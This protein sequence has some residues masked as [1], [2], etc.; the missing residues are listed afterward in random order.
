[1]AANKGSILMPII[2]MCSY[3][4]LSFNIFGMRTKRPQLENGIRKANQLV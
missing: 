1:M 3:S 4:S 2:T